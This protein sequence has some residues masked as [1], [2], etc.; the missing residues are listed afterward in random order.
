MPLRFDSD[1]A[2]TAWKQG[3]RG[4]T[5]EEHGPGA[6][7]K[8]RRGHGGHNDHGGGSRGRVSVAGTKRGR[9]KSAGG[10]LARAVKGF[11]RGA[12][13]DFKRRG[14]GRQRD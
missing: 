10:K 14:V 3:L 8:G 7:P 11:A 5:A 13:R 1:T 4:F 12:G 6:A 9:G 2:Y